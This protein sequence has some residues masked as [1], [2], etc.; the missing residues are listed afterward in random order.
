MKLLCIN[1]EFPPIGGGGATACYFLTKELEQMGDSCTVITSS[2][3]DLP[4]RETVN[5]CRVIRVKALRRKRDKSTFLEMLTFMF[6]AFFTAGRLLRKESFDRCFI[7]FGIPSGPL[8]WYIKKRYR[9][10]YIIRI[11]GGDIPGSQDRFQIL[12]RL[13]SLPL[14]RIWKDASSVVANSEGLERRARAFYDCSHLQV[15]TNGVDHQYFSRK[16]A[17]KKYEVEILFVSRLLE[18]KGLQYVIPRMKEIQERTVGEVH[19]SI[20]GD[21]PY[22]EE[23]AQ[24]I[25]KHGMEGLVS[26]EGRQDKESLLEYYSR[27]DIFILPSRGEGMPNVVLEAMAMKLPIIMTPCEGSKEL[28]TD[29]GIIADYKHFSDAVVKLAN[30]RELRE[31]MGNRSREIAEDRFQW[32][33]IAR[34]YRE[35][36]EHHE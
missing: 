31:K 13:L 34:Q 9:I 6:S 21:G 29:N 19:L 23:L 16:T 30:D 1:H 17:E 28:V 32:K 4:A 20:V 8:G 36:L 22:R 26:M 7:F 24:I 27:A 2:F 14:K 35:V 15:I 11:G 12:Y 10:P 5:G 18:G 3:A 25:R 33:H